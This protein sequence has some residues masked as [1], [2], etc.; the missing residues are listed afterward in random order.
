PAP[1]GGVAEP[2]GGLSRTQQAA[3]ALIVLSV[4][5]VL[6]ALALATTS[7]RR[8]MSNPPTVPPTA[9]TVRSGE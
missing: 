6:I 8:R 9:G 3:V 1:A 7:L 5:L 4:L 2:K